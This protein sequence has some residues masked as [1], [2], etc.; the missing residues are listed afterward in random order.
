MYGELLGLW[1]VVVGLKQAVM[2]MIGD[3]NHGSLLVTIM[4]SDENH[5]VGIH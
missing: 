2:V 5:D 4:S 1:C 3:D